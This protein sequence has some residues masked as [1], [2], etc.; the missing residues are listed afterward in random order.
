MIEHLIAC[1]FAL[2]AAV[3]GL[4]LTQTPP[5]PGPVPQPPALD[6]KELADDTKLKTASGATFTVAKG[7]HVAQ[8]ENLIVIQE[9]LRELSAAFVEVAAPTA[10]EAIAN[11]WKRWQPG[12]SRTVRMTMKPPTM[13]GWDEVVQHVYQTGTEERRVVIG[14]ARRKGST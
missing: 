3:P 6:F 1:L 9:P 13:Q 12:F 8:L 4:E 14:A 10:E 7:W 11:A 2:V 5:A